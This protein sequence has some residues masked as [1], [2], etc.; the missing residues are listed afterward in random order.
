[1]FI[2]RAVAAGV[3][4]LSGWRLGKVIVDFAGR[5]VEAAL[6]V[7][8]CFARGAAPFVNSAREFLFLLTADTTHVINRLIHARTR[9]V[10]KLSAARARSVDHIFCT[11]AKVSCLAPSPV[12]KIARSP[13][14]VLGIFVRTP[15]CTARTPAND[16]ARLFS[17]L[18]REE[19]G[20]SGADGE[21]GEK[22]PDRRACTGAS[23]DDH[24][25]IVIIVP[26]HVRTSR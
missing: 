13:T 18:R 19:K 6:E 26:A 4:S 9:V 5:I 2:R 3:S 1:M 25:I 7:A 21:P 24:A 8:A 23:L 14:D 16:T 22:G 17:A 12:A 10:D 15:T 20:N 11:I